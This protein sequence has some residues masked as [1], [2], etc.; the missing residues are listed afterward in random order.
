MEGLF[1][2]TSVYVCCDKQQKKMKGG[3]QTEWDRYVD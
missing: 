3:G 1:Q 2:D